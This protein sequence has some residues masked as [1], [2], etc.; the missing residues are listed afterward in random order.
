[1]FGVLG[2]YNFA[3]RI[4]IALIKQL[5]EEVPIPSAPLIRALRETLHQMFPTKMGYGK[6]W[7]MNNVKEDLI[8]V[9]I[10]CFWITESNLPAYQM[11][12]KQCRKPEAFQDCIYFTLLARMQQ[13]KLN[14]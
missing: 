12:G 13:E 6:L 14:R 5:F 7:D 2:I 11:C 1:M 10:S 8:P 4:K 9:P 3:T